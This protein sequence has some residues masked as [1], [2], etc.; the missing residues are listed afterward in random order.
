MNNLGFIDEDVN[1]LELE[2]VTNNQAKVSAISTAF[3]PYCSPSLHVKPEAT[4]N[5]VRPFREPQCNR[6]KMKRTENFFRNRTS[7]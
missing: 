7:F 1:E 2:S 5:K 6:K 4:N 3:D